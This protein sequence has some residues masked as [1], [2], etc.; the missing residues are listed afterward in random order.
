VLRAQDLCRAVV[1]N[2]L[3]HG[4]PFF[5]KYPMDHFAMLTPHEQLVETVL[6]KP[7]SSVNAFYW[8]YGTFCGPH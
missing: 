1:I 3:A 2:H 5:K 7:Q 4:P 6:H 8:I